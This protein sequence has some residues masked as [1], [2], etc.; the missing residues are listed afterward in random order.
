M[1]VPAHSLPD[2]KPFWRVQAVSDYEGTGRDFAYTIGL[3]GV[4]LPELHLWARPSE[5]VDPAPD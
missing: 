3:T 5:G 2:E 1:S 4:G